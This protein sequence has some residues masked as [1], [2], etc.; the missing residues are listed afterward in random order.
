M[1][2]I[3][4][5]SRLILR[6]VLD[7]V[8]SYLM[9]ISVPLTVL[10]SIESLRAWFFWSADLDERRMS[11]VRWDLVLPNKGDGGLRLGVFCV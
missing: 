11:W 9:S 4:I 6:N 2:C 1:K 7:S 5:G 8:R 10:S 3:S